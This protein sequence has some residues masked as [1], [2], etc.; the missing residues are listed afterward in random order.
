MSAL[1]GDDRCVSRLLNDPAGMRSASALLR[2][3]A[4][5][6]RQISRDLLAR[7]G[8]SA[9]TLTPVVRELDQ[10]CQDLMALASHVTSLAG[11]VEKADEP[12][13]PGGGHFPKPNAPS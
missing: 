10:V 7:H 4:E 6:C 13:P 11:A 12:P 8:A 3:A 5:S 2:L 1:A 9:G